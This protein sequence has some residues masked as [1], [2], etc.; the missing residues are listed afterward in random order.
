MSDD[1]VSEEDYSFFTSR[2][3]PI[4]Y[5]IKVE[6]LVCYSL[7]DVTA[8]SLV[9]SHKSTSKR[10]IKVGIF[11]NPLYSPNTSAQPLQHFWDH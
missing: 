1:E 10:R 8:Q 9:N 7:A 4:T 5:R 11:D 6:S 3:T 2:C